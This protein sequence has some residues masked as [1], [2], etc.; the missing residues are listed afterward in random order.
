MIGFMNALGI[1]IFWSQNAT[2]KVCNKDFFLDCETNELSWMDWSD[3]G[4]TLAM[5]AGT[6]LMI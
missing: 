1:I 5:V 2:Y 3:I 6:I 4:Y